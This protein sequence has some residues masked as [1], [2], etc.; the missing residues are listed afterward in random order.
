MEELVGLV[1]IVMQEI[2]RGSLLQYRVLLQTLEYRLLVYAVIIS[3]MVPAT[4]ETLHTAI[5]KLLGMPL[6]LLLLYN[7]VIN[8]A[9]Q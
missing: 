7:S 3:V 1:L 4:L 5:I 8:W 2:P 6:R 9:E